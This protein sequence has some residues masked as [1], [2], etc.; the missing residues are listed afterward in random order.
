MRACDPRARCTRKR[1]ATVS[2][3]F[4]LALQN[5][6]PLR[7]RRFSQVAAISSQAPPNSGRL[8][9]A[10]SGQ[11]GTKT[12]L[13]LDRNILGSKGAEWTDSV[14]VSPE[15]RDGPAQERHMDEAIERLALSA[16]R[17][18]RKSRRS[19]NAAN[20]LPRSKP[21]ELG[22]HLTFGVDRELDSLEFSLAGADITH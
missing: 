4:R 21:F 22:S 16:F 9:K 15:Q 6:S 11:P 12:E 7:R 3:L 18:I 13:L 8:C 14:S 2:K 20:P 5:S 1:I 10:R 19:P 17:S